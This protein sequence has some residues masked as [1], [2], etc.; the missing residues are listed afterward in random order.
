MIDVTTEPLLA[1]LDLDADALIQRPLARRDTVLLAKSQRLATQRA[2]ELM[3]RGDVHDIL[4]IID[5][6]WQ[7]IVAARKNVIVAGVNYETQI[8]NLEDNSKRTSPCYR[9]MQSQEVQK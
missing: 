1:G 5:R 9:G 2:H 6:N 8:D 4:D 7:R 3:V